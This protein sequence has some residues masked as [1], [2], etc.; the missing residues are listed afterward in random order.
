LRWSATSASL[1]S[2][3]RAPAAERLRRRGQEVTRAFVL[4]HAERFVLTEKNRPSASGLASRDSRWDWRARRSAERN[5]AANCAKPSRIRSLEEAEGRRGR[6]HLAELS[7]SRRQY[8]HRR[9]TDARS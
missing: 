8:R 9:A 4:G 2:C 5:R 7:A 6:L 1:S 3:A